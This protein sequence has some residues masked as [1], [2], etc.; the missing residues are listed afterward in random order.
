M[1]RGASLMKFRSGRLYQ[2][3]MLAFVAA[4]LGGLPVQSY[5]QTQPAASPAPSAAPEPT[6]AAD[7]KVVLRVGK[8]EVTKADMDQLIS[9]LGAQARQSVAKDGRRSVGE[10]YAIMMILDQQAEKDHL[11]S[12]PEI[13]QRLEMERR[14]VLAQAEY[15]KM[16]EQIQVTPD[17]VGQYFNAHKDE[18][19]EVALHEIMVRKKAPDAKPDATGLTPAQAQTKIDAIRKALTAGTDIAKI[20][21]EFGVP[22]EVIIDSEARTVRRGQLL[23]ALDKQAFSLKDGQISEPYQMPQAIVMFQ[24]IKHQPPDLKNASSQIENE[25]HQEKLRAEIANLQKSANVWMDED[26]FK[27][28]SAPEAPA[29]DQPAPQTHPQAKPP[30]PPPQKP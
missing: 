26:Y 2:A 24:V 19:D 29:A 30:A 27:P 15:Q 21:K 28:E 23:P 6:A 9:G 18:F 10:Q 22:N 20:K 7:T 14:Q 25:L 3:A 11:D 17:E 4:I 5:G 13:R 12:S 16:E 8:E 1:V